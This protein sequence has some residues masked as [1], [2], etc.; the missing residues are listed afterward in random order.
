VA[1]AAEEAGAD[2]LSLINTLVGMAID[3]DTRRPK[4]GNIT[5]G[6]SG[7]AIRPVAVAMVANDDA[8]AGAVAASAL[9]IVYSVAVFGRVDEFS[10]VSLGLI[11]LFGGLS[12]KF[13]DGVY[14]KFKPVVL[15][16]AMAAAFFVTYAWGH[17]LL[18][19][20]AERYGGVLPAA[21]QQRLA[22][23]VVRAALDRAS[24]NLGFGLIFQA[25]LVGWAALRLNTWWWFAVRSV[26]FYLMVFAVVWI[27]L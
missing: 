10:Y 25:A 6:L 18:R 20:S 24:L 19:M 14:F 17:P 4:L 13:D 8:V 15:N 11:A 7:P 1:R 16:L 26:G 21:L 9:E 22:L 3:V 27:S 23:P 2:A 5:G 12:F